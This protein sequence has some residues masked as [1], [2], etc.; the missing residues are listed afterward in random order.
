MDNKIDIV[1]TIWQLLGGLWLLLLLGI[2][3]FIAFF[4]FAGRH[5]AMISIGLPEIIVLA[6]A[7]AFLG[8]GGIVAIVAGGALKARRPWARV[9]IVILSFLNLLS[10]PVGTAVGVFSLIVLL[11]ANAKTAFA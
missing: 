7:I 6:A 3:G 8:V 9:V 1:G 10:F 4:S 11:D 5:H 2:F